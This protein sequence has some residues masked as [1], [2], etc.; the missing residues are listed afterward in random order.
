LI[1][2]AFALFGITLFL[3]F[4]ARLLIWFV[5]RNTRGGRS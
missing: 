5:E 1:S 4:G 2:V 3:N